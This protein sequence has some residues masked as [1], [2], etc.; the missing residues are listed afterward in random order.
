MATLVDNFLG[1]ETPLY[2]I[3]GSE[4]LFNVTSDPA[5]FASNRFYLIVGHE[6]TG[7]LKETNINSGIITAS[8]NPVM[9]SNVSIKL[10]G[11]NTGKYTIKITKSQD[12]FN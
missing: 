4:I 6:R 11:F 9:G 3:G 8:P 2:L 7:A 12:F 10:N 1:T 5:S